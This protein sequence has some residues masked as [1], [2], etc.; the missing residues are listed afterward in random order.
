M[1][2]VRTRFELQEMEV[3]TDQTNGDGP[4]SLCQSMKALQLIPS[5]KSQGRVYF[6]CDYA[7][8]R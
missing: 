5:G 7:P 4:E 6:H 3:E 8:G 2:S 1:L